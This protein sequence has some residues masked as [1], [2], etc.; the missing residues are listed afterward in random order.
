MVGGVCR[1]R[2]PRYRSHQA[3]H[4]CARALAEGRAACP[5][6]EYGASPPAPTGR[7]GRSRPTRYAAPLQSAEQTGAAASGL[8]NSGLRADS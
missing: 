4:P 7:A 8:H 3:R 5:T 6:E 2:D 1:W